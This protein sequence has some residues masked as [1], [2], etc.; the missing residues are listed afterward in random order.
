M[1]IMLWCDPHT[2]ELLNDDARTATE[3]RGREVSVDECASARLTMGFVDGGRYDAATARE[4][5][6]RYREIM[7]HRIGT[8]ERRRQRCNNRNQ[9]DEMGGMEAGVRVQVYRDSATEGGDGHYK[10]H[11]E[12]KNWIVWETKDGTL[13]VAN[14]RNAAGAIVGAAVIVPK[15]LVPAKGDDAEQPEKETQG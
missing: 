7:L 13:Y 12:T 1:M 2:L 6:D 8:A 3:A 5:K 15:N 11:V 4:M 10:G 14:G 9:E